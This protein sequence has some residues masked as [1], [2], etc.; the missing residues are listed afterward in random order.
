YLQEGARRPQAGAEAV[1]WFQF[2]ATCSKTNGARRGRQPVA[3]ENGDSRKQCARRRESP[4]SA[5]AKCLSSAT[6]SPSLG[7]LHHELILPRRQLTTYGQ[8]PTSRRRRSAS[9]RGLNLRRSKCRGFPAVAWPNVRRRR[10]R[11]SA[12]IP[13]QRED[14]CC[15]ARL[16]PDVAPV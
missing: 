14:H 1:R 12:V 11:K 16:A 7:T 6:S 4:E 2:A 13:R 5:V 8:A 15:F 3:I 10:R 9:R